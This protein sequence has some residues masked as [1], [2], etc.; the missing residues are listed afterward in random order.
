MK[1]HKTLIYTYLAQVCEEI[2][3]IEG[4]YKI[5]CDIL[6]ELEV[7]KMLTIH[8]IHLRP[9][10]INWVVNQGAFSCLQNLMLI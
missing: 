7:A 6:S 5:H 10:P 1:R 2:L 8:L 3:V 9:W 4:K